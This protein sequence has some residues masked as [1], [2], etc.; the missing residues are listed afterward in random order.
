MAKLRSTSG[1][2]IGYIR[3]AA[4]VMHALAHPARLKLAE[5][6]LLHGPLGVSDLAARTNLPINQVSQHLRV[7]A[8]AKAIT[9]KPRGRRVTCRLTHALAANLVR[10]VQREHQLTQSFRDGEAI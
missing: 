9:R 4:K 1:L 6:L 2:P 7:M 8:D 10:T 3:E 5:L